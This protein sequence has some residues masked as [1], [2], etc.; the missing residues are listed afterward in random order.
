MVKDIFDDVFQVLLNILDQILSYLLF[1]KYVS[2]FLISK[3]CE[4]W[5][6]NPAEFRLQTLSESWKYGL[7]ELLRLKLGH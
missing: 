3:L 4:F 5:P 6:A 1:L 7:D 2:P